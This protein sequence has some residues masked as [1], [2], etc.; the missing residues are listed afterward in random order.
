MVIYADIF[1]LINLMIDFLLLAGTNRLC[2]SSP[3]F[4]R[5]LLGASLGALYATVCILPGFYFLGNTLWRAVSLVGIAVAAYGLQRNTL[6]KA[7][8]FLFL[9]MAL[10]GISTGIG[11]G[12]L[13]HLFL[14]V[15]LLGLVAFASFHGGF[16]QKRYVPVE[17][18]FG[19]LQKNLTAL[20]DTGNLLRDP[21]SGESVLVVGAEVATEMLGLD[22]SDPVRAVEQG[23]VPGLRLIPFRSLGNPGGM[24]VGLKLDN[25]R[26]DGKEGSKIIGFSPY[27]F[28]E[29][30][31][32]QAL[33]G[34]IAT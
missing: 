28:G 17:L 8:V 3:R 20:V 6:R 31:T 15:L 23:A 27:Q 10:G 4:G 32:Y 2:G 16:A 11:K 14:S 19:S 9:S 30:C 12:D 33:A 18:R 34:G 21:I 1:F 29:N 7:S 22:V 13:P 26:I 25:V 24:L 5:C